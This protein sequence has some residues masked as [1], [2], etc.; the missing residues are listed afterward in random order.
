V[1]SKL[2]IDAVKHVWHCYV[3]IVHSQLLEDN[4]EDMLKA[5][6]RIQQSYWSNW[7]KPKDICINMMPFVIGDSTS[8]PEEFRAYCSLLERI[9]FPNEELGEIGYLTIHESTVEPGKTQR[10]PGIHID[11]PGLLMSD[12]IVESTESGWGM[13]FF[14]KYQPHGGIYVISNV[15]N[16]C[17]V[18]PLSV[19]NPSEI[20]GPGGD[21]DHL[22]DF[23]GEP[24]I[25]ESRMLYWMTDRTPHAAL[26]NTEKKAVYR[27]FVRVTTPDV[28]V[29]FSDHSTPNR[30]GI[31]PG[32]NVKIIS[33]DKFEFF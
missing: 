24:E 23:L 30:L 33:G 2:T 4:D 26:P 1:F 11:A 21:I 9:S 13:G 10:R 16:S 32:P 25:M 5:F 19:K 6:V 12:G 3:E 7:P 14:T 27:Q 18:W 15:D 8:I 20:V 29:W 22:A 31:T 28:S 17:A